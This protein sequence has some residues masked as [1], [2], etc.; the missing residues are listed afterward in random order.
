[1]DEECRHRDFVVLLDHGEA[2]GQLLV[3][4]ATGGAIVLQERCQL[5]FDDDCNGGFAF[6]SAEG[7]GSDGDDDALVWV[8]DLFDRSYYIAGPGESDGECFVSKSSGS[9]ELRADAIR[10]MSAEPFIAEG[11]GGKLKLELYQHE[12]PKRLVW[13]RLFWSLSRVQGF[14]F[15][16]ASGCKWL[17]KNFHRL[18]DMVRSRGPYQK[19]YLFTTSAASAPGQ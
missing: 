12:V 10:R 2:H 8:S 17:C 18:E 9:R 15:G 11:P 4:R 14:I 13:L 19:M 16:P 6:L 5:Q 1:M 3:H 7:S